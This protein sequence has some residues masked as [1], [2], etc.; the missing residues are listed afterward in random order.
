MK[1]LNPNTLLLFFFATLFEV[2]A[3]FSQSVQIVPSVFYDFQIM[4]ETGVGDLQMIN[5]DISINDKGEIAFT[6]KIT[7]DPV[8]NKLFV[9]KEP[10]SLLQLSPS[11]N[12]FDVRPGVQINNDSWV[13]A[14]DNQASTGSTLRSLRIWST[15]GT[16]TWEKLAVGD[17]EVASADFDAVF[18]YPSINNK[19]KVVFSALNPHV[20]HGYPTTG[21]DV[22]L[23]YLVPILSPFPI[24]PNNL[25]N[26]SY[27]TAPS[28]SSGANH[29]IAFTDRNR[30]IENTPAT[31]AYQP[32]IADNG[33]IVLWENERN[34]SVG[35]ISTLT[36]S[37]ASADN[38]FTRLGKRPGICDDGSAIAFYGENREEGK[39]IFVYFFE[40]DSL[41]KITGLERG[42]ELGF[43]YEGMDL[44]PNVSIIT[45]D[46]FGFTADSR[47]G[48]MRIPLNDSGIFDDSFV[49]CF[50][51]TP[52]Q[53]SRSNPQL[54]LKPLLFSDQ[55]GL[56]STTLHIKNDF[57]NGI[58]NPH[59]LVEVEGFVPVAQKGDNIG[60]YQIDNI[61]IYDPIS[62]VSFD[63]EYTDRVRTQRRGDHQICFSATTM[64]GNSI[65]LKA[66]HLDSDQDGLLDHWEYPGRGI[67][68]NKDGRVD[69]NLNSM[70]AVHGIR[71]IFLEIDWVS[72][73]LKNNKVIH[74]HSLHDDVG[75]SLK[76]MF[77]MAPILKGSKHGYVVEG[78][79]SE[80]TSGIQFHLDV[81]PSIGLNGK[82]LSFGMGPVPLNGGDIKYQ[83]AQ[84][85]KHYDMV[86][87]GLPKDKI[88]SNILN[89]NFNLKSFHEFKEMFFGTE[90]FFARELV[91][92]YAV[93][94]DFK[95][96][97]PKAGQDPFG[98]PIVRTVEKANYTQTDFNLDGINDIIIQYIGEQIQYDRKLRNENS[99]GSLV[100][101]LENACFY[102]ENR[103]NSK[104]CSD[105]I[106][107][108]GNQI[109][110][111]GRLE[112]LPM[113][114]DSFLIIDDFAGYAEVPGNDMVISLGSWGKNKLDE[115]L[116]LANNDIQWRT[117]AHELGH[118]LGL[119]HC[120]N[121]PDAGI[122]SEYPHKFRS[123][124]NPAQQLN[125]QYYGGIPP[126][127]SYASIMD[128]YRDFID[129]NYFRDEWGE[130]E[131]DFVNINQNIGNTLELNHN[132][133][134][135]LFEDEISEYDYFKFFGEY[136][137]Y[138][139]PDIKISTNHNDT[140]FVG[141]ELV[142]QAVAEDASDEIFIRF[143]FDV[144]GNG[145]V[146]NHSEIFSAD[147]VNLNRFSI[148]ITEIYGPPGMRELK[149]IGRDEW[150]NYTILTKDIIVYDSTG[151][152]LKPP[153][154]SVLS[155][156]ENTVISLGDSVSL[157]FIAADNGTLRTAQVE[158][159]VNGDNQISEY[160]EKFNLTPSSNDTFAVSIKNIEGPSGP[161][162][163]NVK[164]RDSWRNEN[165]ASRVIFLSEEDSSRTQGPVV[166]F[167]SSLNNYIVNSSGNLTLQLEV[168]DE[169]EITSV[170]LLLD[171]DGNGI[172]NKDESIS[173]TY[174]GGKRYSAYIENVRGKPGNRAV[175]AFAI[176]SLQ[177]I[178][179]TSNVLI[180]PDNNP[181]SI[182]IESPFLGEGF[183]VGDTVDIEFEIW[184]ETI[185]DSL[186]ISLDVD[187]SGMIDM[188]NEVLRPIISQIGRYNV[189]FENIFGELRI[190]TI[191][192]Y[193]RDTTGNSVV[194]SKIISVLDTNRIEKSRNV[195][196]FKESFGI[197]GVTSVKYSSDGSM[198]LMGGDHGTAV[199]IDADSFYII[200]RF[201]CHNQAITSVAFSPDDN[202]IFTGSRD[203]SVRQWDVSDGALIREF[204]HRLSIDSMYYGYVNDISIS[205]SGTKLL[206]GTEG[207]FVN[208][209]WLWDIENERF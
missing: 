194:V 209:A 187:G 109:I 37:I 75:D 94:T 97:H 189:S 23:S 138:D 153:D 18:P 154:L 139:S 19:N 122:C 35:S 131:M 160:T 119:L 74:D 82:P 12:N 103:V 53:E 110:L 27:G 149:C 156:N 96:F 163:I 95:G 176:N 179:S 137:D 79:V 36:R 182:M 39:G 125:R 126:A 66:I 148:I 199:L 150:G 133:N 13:V 46:E 76:K 123:L 30:N 55:E 192:I 146:D 59:L 81:G 178:G 90:D 88:F 54:P 58:L 11:Y 93:L 197:G 142:A 92:H 140:I 89:Q 3:V 84:G 116:R 207:N 135:T 87:F 107:V 157:V 105:V 181:P 184:E 158:F 49:V 80:I 100:G 101:V 114:G 117:L 47:V 52:N 31:K 16:N 73:K 190:R 198:V 9:I 61:E 106:V 159:D 10:G 127:I 161:R 102:F 177:Q 99:S 130:L 108:E 28:S 167:L 43:K 32:V 134:L 143:T 60:L 175:Y 86:Y 205:P 132:Q 14:Q 174:I 115:D 173:C 42:P 98:Q 183:S 7:S 145:V 25:Y 51:G 195:M 193:A 164:V 118:N 71:D 155:P 121:S 162:S 201:Y 185:I 165:N 40:I 70:G 26:T 204:N 69:L 15:Q 17:F 6:G 44:D 104:T 111:D 144:N 48:I 78:E 22:D 120:G 21:V 77:A 171:I 1:T 65:V 113:Q 38:G 141:Q 129:A 206:T 208:F 169:M 91:F 186:S 151:R 67:D 4:A 41:V 191:R 63:P 202:Y 203:F 64:N 33:V 68:I 147:R 34:D 112:E 62:Q 136:P 72:P 166:T 124:M 152:D 200:K 172:I 50:K 57:S 85:Y 128:P 24:D 83:G 29:F 56:W 5:D 188:P 2:T 20:N 8:Y 170:F 45:F 168:E 196:P 180:V